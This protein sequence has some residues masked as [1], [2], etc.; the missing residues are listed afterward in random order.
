MTQC[1]RYIH[2]HTKEEHP[3]CYRRVSEVRFK[4]KKTGEKQ[5]YQRR[6]IYAV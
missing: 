1:W 6:L 4:A 5:G 2:R 3:E